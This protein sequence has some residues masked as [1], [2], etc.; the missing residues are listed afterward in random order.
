M[1]SNHLRP[2][3]VAV[4]D[5]RDAGLR[6]AAAEA[7]REGRPLRIV[8]VL[9]PP[10]G[11]VRAD[12]ESILI[13]FESAEMVA[14]QLLRGQYERAMA[15][16]GGRVSVKKSL[17]RGGV[18]QMLLGLSKNADHIV[19]LHRREERFSHLLTGSTATA[20]AAVATVPV[21]SVPEVWA[22][23]RVTPHV[24]VGLGDEDLDDAD[25]LL[26]RAFYEA[27][28]RKA[29]LTVIHTRYQPTAYSDLA[30][31]RPPREDWQRSA[32]SR[33]D[34]RLTAWQEAQPL[35]DTR[36]EVS[37]ERPI[38][39]LVRASGHSDVLIVGRRPSHGLVHLGSVVHALVCE[40]LCPVL[41][42]GRPE[43]ERDHPRQV[44]VAAS[45]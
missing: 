3:L 6:Y 29:I 45:S 25:H 22:G 31:G 1:S 35:V 17:R 37:H 9:P 14:E 21:V 11:S 34:A 15:I 32:R 10:Q 19:L 44:R 5:E 36:V 2:I 41:V 13:S 28:A 24:T 20:L 43:R 18:V 27:A 30:T 33:I 12:P 39:G 26:G 7:V 23:A 16:V 42:V 8:H 40:S 4:A 38:D